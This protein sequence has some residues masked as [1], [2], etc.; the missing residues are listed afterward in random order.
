MP[1]KGSTEAK[2]FNGRRYVFL[3]YR[4]TKKEA[5]DAAELERD[6]GWKVRVVRTKIGKKIYYDLYGRKG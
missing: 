4:H 5:R 2:V 6:R 3:Y 1:Y